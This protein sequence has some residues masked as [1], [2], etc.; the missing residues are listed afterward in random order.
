[1]KQNERL[2]EHG[3]RGPYLT[4]YELA[5]GQ[6]GFEARI[7]PGILREAEATGEDPS[8]WDRFGFLTRVAEA[9]RDVVPPDAPLE[10]LEE[11]R[12]L[13]FHAFNFWRFGR[14]LYVLEQR[15]VRYLVEAAPQLD[16][17]DFSLPHPSVYVQLPPRLFWA[18]I[19][20]DAAPEPVDGFFVMLARGHDPLGSS[21]GDLNVLMVLGLRRDRAG[22]SVIPFDT[23]VGPG[24]SATWMEAPGREGAPDFANILPGGDMAGLYSILTNTEALKLLART[25]WY[26]QGNPGQLHPESP[27]ERRVEDRAG[28]VPLTRLPFQRVSLELGGIPPDGAAG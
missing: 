15:T 12:S 2:V 22:F 21:Y 7:F 1:V 24:I 26:I 9:L 20:T 19:A 13:F 5:F 10:M 16:G 25:L 28:S 27:A 17:W 8:R 11:Y 18:S 6:A 3:D 14:R 4:P 23:E